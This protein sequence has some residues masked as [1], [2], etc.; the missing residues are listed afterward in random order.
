MFQ[1]PADN[2]R[3]FVIEQAGR[4]R[5]FANQSNVNAMSDFIDIRPRVAFGGELGL[6]GLAFHPNFASNHRVYLSYTTGSGPHVSR[7][8]QFTSTDGG[9]TLDPNSEAILLA[10]NQPEDNHN[11]GNIAFGADGFL[12]VGFGD[13][14]GGGD[15]HPP[16]GNGQKLT[17]LLGKILRID[18]NGAAP[19]AIPSSN[20]FAANASCGVNGSGTQNCPEIYAWGFRNPWRFSFD[21]STADLWVGDVG[22]GN[23]EEVDQVV[24]GGNYGWRCREGAHDFNIANCPAAGL[25][26]PVAEY[27]HSVG[28]SITGGY[29]YRGTQF[30]PLVGRYLFGDFGTGRIWTWIPGGIPRQ[31]T[32]L[33]AT[34]LSISSF[35]QGN[36]GELYAVNYGG[37]LHHL[38]FAGGA[39]SDN[40][41]STLSSTGCVN[42]GN[43]TQAS[44]GMIPYAVNAPFWSD[45]A[46]KERWLGLPNGQS[47]SVASDGDWQF[48]MGSVLM[49]NFRINNALVETRLLVNHPDGTWAGYT[50][51]WNSAQTDA[52]RVQGGAT[53]TLANG[54]AW[55]FPSEAQCLQC[56]TAA[57]GRTLGLET[58]QLNRDYTYP[59]T[60]RTANQLVTHTAINTVSPPYPSN[61]QMLASMPDPTDVSASVDSRARA[62]LHTNCAQCHRPGGPTSSTMD[63]RYT[64][65]LAN[66][67]ACNVAPTSG[68]LGITG[69][70]LITPGNATMSVLPARM[71]RRG[72]NAMPPLG[73]NLVDSVGVNLITQWI[74]SLSGC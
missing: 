70:R 44:S 7:I 10:V 33:A 9:L 67:N 13:G 11:G 4:V 1:A 32:Q 71:N 45:G 21:S 68:D 66:T 15:T 2:S 23:W 48:P 20:P 47:I 14:G 6:L 37:T 63:L 38:V 49:K 19:Y 24:R 5:V 69:A 30:A 18:V 35:G 74:N 26:D 36:D 39:V 56:H 55:L 16:D 42:Q 22:Q 64:T 54:Q 17:T 59:Q 31:P 57:A 73:S 61:V 34:N 28:V 53:R 58:A 51:E 40:T 8:S 60:G 25:I 46:A 29:V 65:T 43:A 3:W 52:T 27:D 12:Y 50:Y 72:A 62:Y 41:P